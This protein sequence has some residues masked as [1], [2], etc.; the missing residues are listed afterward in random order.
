MDDVLQREWEVVIG[1]WLQS[2]ILAVGEFEAR[3]S[4][5]RSAAGGNREGQRTVKS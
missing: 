2:D 3:V 4:F 1:E 5:N